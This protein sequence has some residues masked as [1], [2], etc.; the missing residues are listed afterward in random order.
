MEDSGYSEVR[1]V[2]DLQGED[3]LVKLM[4]HDNSAPFG[5]S[6]IY[7]GWLGWSVDENG[8]TSYDFEMMERILN[9][10]S[11]NNKDSQNNIASDPIRICLCKDGKP[12]CNNT[13]DLLVVYGHAIRLNL[14]AVGQQFTTVPSFVK[15][16]LISGTLQ[17]GKRIQSLQVNCTR[18]TYK[19]NP[20]AQRLVLKPCFDCHGQQEPQNF[21]KNC[22]NTSVTAQAL[23]LFQPLSIQL[24]FRNCPLGFILNDND[25]KCVCQSLYGLK[26]DVDDYKVYR[27]QKQWI[28][29]TH[30]YMYTTAGKKSL[31]VIVHEHCPFDYCRTESL[32]I[33][34][35]DQDEQC[36]FNRTG[37]LCGECKS[38]FSRV[39]GS[40]S[41]KEC[42][43][44]I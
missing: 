25:G 19:I 16:S 28:G 12:D 36:A 26:C 39:L 10:D 21:P 2:F 31:G 37:I 24:K 42:S 6:Q 18:I 30:E 17:S 15:A 34:L 41:C 4:F 13:Q 38:N 35:E 20:E 11:H 7:G 29:V 43:S 40:S 5:R 23:L 9:F 8:T 44:N 1:S 3:T 22:D 27:G 33:S 14:V 32:S